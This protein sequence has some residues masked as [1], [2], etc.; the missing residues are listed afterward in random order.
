MTQPYRAI[1]RRTL[2]RHIG[3]AGATLP[4]ITPALVRAV[5]PNSK[6]N[7]AH[8]GVGGKGWEDMISSS[9]SGKLHNVA[10]IC[11]VD[12]RTNAKHPDNLGAA[13]KKRP[14]GIH[15]AA[16]RFPKATTH[17]DFRKM[18]DK[19]RNEIDA[20]TVSTPDHM[21]ASVAIR[22]MLLGK[23]VYVQKPLAWCVHEAR[24]MRQVASKTGVV[25]QMGNQGHSSIGYRALVEVLRRSDG[26]G[27]IR[28]THA[29]TKSPSWPQNID[30]P[31]G[32]DPIPEGLHW[33]LWLGCAPERPFKD[34]T[35]VPFNWR[36]WQQ[37]GTGAQGD[38]GC[39]IMDPVVWS[40]A[41]GPPSTVESL[42]PK[43]NGE[44]FPKWTTTR[45]RFPA[46]P[47]T[48][49]D[50][51]TVTWYDGGKLPPIELAQMGK[52]RRLPS[53]GTLYIGDKG[54]IVISHHPTAP[55]A[56]PDKDFA[57]FNRTVVREVYKSFEPQDHYRMWT[58]AI[59]AGRPANSH[60]DYA[61]P[62]AET[63]LLGN[64]ALR[65]PKQTLRWDAE[66][67]RFPN[68]PAADAYL[69]RDYRKGWTLESM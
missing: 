12:H 20:V 17:A 22:A 60:F 44:T 38:M 34:N 43:P 37:F 50:G 32:S 13:Q 69:H 9:D 46:T 24:L 3:Y 19:H 47:H 4:A 64:V 59:L 62:L 2:L 31:S 15:A 52:G 27:K 23:H 54:A 8:V 42:G 49:P 10:A 25:T 6:L 41:L 56:Y 5:S 58:D 39:H 66:K 67:M 11:D 48:H 35:Y 30:R 16:D 40:L 61:G 33:D 53:N 55:R 68:M 18:L 21:H 65:F 51:V 7:L 14:I 26:I 29:W 45:Y 57:D 36:G 63:V 28:E 1:T